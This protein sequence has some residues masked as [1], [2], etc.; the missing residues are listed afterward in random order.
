[1]VCQ[2]SRAMSCGISP[3]IS[4]RVVMRLGMRK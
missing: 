1:M 3:G 2:A 4:L